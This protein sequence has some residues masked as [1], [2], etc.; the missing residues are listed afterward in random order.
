MKNLAECLVGQVVNV[1]NLRRV[2]NPPSD[3]WPRPLERRLSTGAQDTILPHEDYK[4]AETKK[5]GRGA[6]DLHGRTVWTDET[7]TATYI[8]LPWRLTSSRV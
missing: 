3:L 5:A 8:V 4:S 2:A 6:E 1:V 7:Y